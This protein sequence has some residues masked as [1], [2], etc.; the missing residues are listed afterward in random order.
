VRI[1]LARLV[2]VAVLAAVLV[3]CA[4]GSSAYKKGYVAARNHDWDTAVAH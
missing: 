2:P 4:S 1:A 3:G